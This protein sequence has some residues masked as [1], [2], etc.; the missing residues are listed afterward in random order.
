[1]GSG[2]GRLVLIHLTL[3]DW[4]ACGGR[5]FCRAIPETRRNSVARAL[6][7]PPRRFGRALHKLKAASDPSGA[8]RVIIDSDGTVTDAH[9]EPIGN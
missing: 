5:G 9:G 2:L 7:M 8:D 4:G 1:M 6:G 3:A